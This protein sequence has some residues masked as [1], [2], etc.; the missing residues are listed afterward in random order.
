M[1]GLTALLTITCVALPAAGPALANARMRLPCF[2]RSILPAW[3]GLT[4]NSLSGQI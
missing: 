2:G 4:G 3:P 1:R